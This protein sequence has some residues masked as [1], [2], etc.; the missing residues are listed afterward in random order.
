MSSATGGPVT[1]VFRPRTSKAFTVVAFVLTAVGL[2][3]VVVADGAAGLLAAWPLAAFAFTAWWLFWY[4]SV[5]V[6]ASA[7]TL[8]NPLTTVSVP[9]AALVHVDTKY[10]LKLITPKGSYTA[11][12]AP[13]PGV[14]GTHAGRPEHLSNLPGSSYG[15]GGSV[16]PG[17]LKHTD[18]GFAAFLV[19]SRWE[20]MINN[21][22]LDVDL[23][24]SAVVAR[25]INWPLILAGSLLVAVSFATSALD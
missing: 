4:P 5:T 3:S 7:V 9:W 12:A 25:S 1:T 18:S 21:G 24:E 6:D 14:W 11:W 8:R 22:S 10:A 23:T 2:A 19:R 15:V 13:A 17:D 20:E 16:R